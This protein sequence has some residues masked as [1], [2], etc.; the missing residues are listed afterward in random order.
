[1]ILNA[2]IPNITLFILS[3]CEVISRIY[4]CLIEHG[5]FKYTQYEANLIYEGPPAEIPYK[6]AY[7]FKTIWL[8]ALYTPLVPIVVPISV[9][10]LAI[11]YFL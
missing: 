5:T 3:Y 10:G 8:T 6:Y 2:A 11:N 4:R 1:M 7:V 9:A